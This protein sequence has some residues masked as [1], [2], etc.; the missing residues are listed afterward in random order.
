MKAFYTL[1]N[2]TKGQ[3]NQASISLLKETE[4]RTCKEKYTS[5]WIREQTHAHMQHQESTLLPS[6][7]QPRR[8]RVV[9]CPHCRMMGTD[10]TPTFPRADKWAILSV[11]LGNTIP[12]GS[13]LKWTQR[14][15]AK[16]SPDALKENKIENINTEEVFEKKS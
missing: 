3:V 12:S 10:Y 2:F 7:E 9:G 4:V 13:L 8:V 14:P 15:K 5:L 1:L 6:T 11:P 16:R